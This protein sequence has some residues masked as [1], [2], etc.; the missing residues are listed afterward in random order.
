MFASLASMVKQ[1]WATRKLALARKSRSALMQNLQ[2][3]QHLQH[4]HLPERALVKSSGAD[5][6]G[7]QV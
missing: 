2:R 1:A 3:L 5:H 7:L 4:L 6:R